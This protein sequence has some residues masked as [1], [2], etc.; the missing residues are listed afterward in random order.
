MVI[1]DRLI[2]Q[3]RVIIVQ[4]EVNVFNLYHVNNFVSRFG[5]IEVVM[6]KLEKRA[7]IR[8]LLSK[9]QEGMY[10]RYK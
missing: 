9:L 6:T 2:E 5:S 4:G 1:F 10:R 3:A 8:P 7:M